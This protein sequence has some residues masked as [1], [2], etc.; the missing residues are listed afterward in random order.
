LVVFRNILLTPFNLQVQIF[1]ASICSR[2]KKNHLSTAAD[3]VVGDG[4]GEEF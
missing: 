2:Q 4:C 1:A 3:F